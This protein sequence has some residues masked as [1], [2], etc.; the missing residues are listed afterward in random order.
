MARQ[1]RNLMLLMAAALSGLA[2]AGPV[3]AVEDGLMAVR[4]GASY[5]EILRRFGHSTGILFSAGGAMMYQTQPGLPGGAGL[6][7]FPTEPT[8][9]ETPVWVLPLRPAGIAEGQSEWVY[10][11]RRTKGVA[12]GIILSG[13]GAD[14]V[15]TDVIVAGFQEN[16]KGKPRPVSTEKGIGLQ[17]TFA[18]VLQKYG[19]PPMIEIYA[20]SGAAGT[21]RAAGAARGAGGGAGGAMRAGGARGG[22]RGGGA[23]GRGARGGGAGGRGGGGGGRM[24]GALDAT[25]TAIA[26]GPRYEGQLTGGMMRGG[27]GRG[28][29]AR[30]GGA[31][32]GAGRGAGG[33]GARRGGGGAARRGGTAGRGTLPPLG[34]QALGG[35]AG[36]PTATAVVDNQAISFARDCILT[37]EFVAFTL[38]DMRVVRI[39]VS[40]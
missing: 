33:G 35:A 34:Q 2:L 24:R 40:E 39:H 5:R 25:T 18:E 32:A 20:P 15:V 11:W 14:A 6:P 1:R 7:N 36:L 10:D 26:Q 9:G 38:H 4:I 13:E 21:Q 30:G 22:G 17:D 12:L 19:F 16:L 27:G 31:R 23:G 29:G 37:Y 3:A 8:A 28:G